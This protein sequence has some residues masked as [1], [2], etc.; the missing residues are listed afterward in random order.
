MTFDEKISETISLS[1]ILDSFI[2][3]DES[4]EVTLWNF[5]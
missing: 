1:M 3:D 2:E 4:P 5:S